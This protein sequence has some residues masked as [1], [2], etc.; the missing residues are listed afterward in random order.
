LIFA[1]SA[2]AEGNAAEGAKKKSMCEGCHGIPGYRTAYPEVYSAPKLG[3]QDAAYIVKALKGY[4]SG[5]RRHPTMTAIA[6]SLSEQDMA[7]LA[8]YYSQT[9]ATASAK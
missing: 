4:Q 7:N 3:G 8:A 2:F 1:A 6:A 9:D 5:T